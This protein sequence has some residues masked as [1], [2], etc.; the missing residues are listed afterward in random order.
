MISN[1]RNHWHALKRLIKF[2]VV[3]GIYLSV[4]NVVYHNGMSCTKK[5]TRFH[6][7]S[8]H[9]IMFP[10]NSVCSGWSAQRNIFRSLDYTTEQGTAI[11]HISRLK[12]ECMSTLPKD[13]HMFSGSA[14]CNWLQLTRVTF[15]HMI[16]SHWMGGRYRR[17]YFPIMWKTV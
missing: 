17:F 13:S 15:F 7:L 4:F 9:N 16:L 8:L 3:Y 5:N 1:G 10:G 14:S 12:Y 2:V 6:P 11:L